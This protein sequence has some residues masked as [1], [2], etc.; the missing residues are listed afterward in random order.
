[1]V[2]PPAGRVWHSGRVGSLALSLTAVVM[3]ASPDVVVLP[4]QTTAV[5]ASRAT[6]IADRVAQAMRA[7]GVGLTAMPFDAVAKLRAQ[8][9]GEPTDC[10]G[11]PACVA[12]LGD[13]L[14]ART[15]VA[16]GAGEFEGSVAVHLEVVAVPSAERFMAEDHLL[17]SNL[18]DPAWART[19]SPYAR[20]V[21][22]LAAAATPPPPASTTAPPV[23]R[24]QP[25]R[26]PSGPRPSR[27]P[28]APPAARD[29]VIS[30]QADSELDA[31]GG[32][33]TLRAGR[34]ILPVLTVSGG[35]L[36][37]G[38][39]VAGA[40]V[41]ARATPLAADF[42]VHPVVAL[43]VPVL[44]PASV[45][46]GVRPSLGAEVTPLPW[47]SLTASASY[48]RLLGVADDVK[49]GYWLAGVEVGLRL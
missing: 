43:E 12:R 34:R 45:A 13:R 46:F 28:G 37:T 19:L 38:G 16:V 44:F 15:V 20:S 35:A 4:V 32:M 9:A 48:M 11:D 41:Q 7:E 26:P 30:L 23:A 18:R 47:L 33:V 25:I 24:T 21:L 29:W 10:R 5:A 2:N 39:L 49:P 14:G 42:I 27:P 3:G 40:T 22:A 1:M 17:P 36:V 31:L 6:A 8:G